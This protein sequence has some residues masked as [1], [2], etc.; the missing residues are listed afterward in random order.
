MWREALKAGIALTFI[1]EEQ[2]E[3]PSSVPSQDNVPVEQSHYQR[4]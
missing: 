4:L 1:A 3:F 2:Q